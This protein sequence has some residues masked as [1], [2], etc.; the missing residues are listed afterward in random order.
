MSI[1]ATIKRGLRLRCPAC[2]NGK[3]YSGFLKVQESCSHCSLPLKEHDA[4]DGP[5]YVVMSVMSIKVVV[6]AL[7]LEFTMNPPVWLHIITWIPFT[8]I[9]SLILLR[10]T[11][12]LFIAIQYHHKIGNLK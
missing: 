4:A 7:I 9:G 10:F 5:A 8:I 11:K 3:L 2:W 12:S 6:L 1:L